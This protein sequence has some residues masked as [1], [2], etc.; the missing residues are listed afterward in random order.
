MNIFKNMRQVRDRTPTT[1]E[2]LP[3]LREIAYHIAE[4]DRFRKHPSEYWI[5]AEQQVRK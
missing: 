4:K 3:T 1:K 5:E 2:V